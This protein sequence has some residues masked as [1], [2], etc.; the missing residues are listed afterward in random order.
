MQYKAKG[1]GVQVLNLANISPPG[2]PPIQ[3]PEEAEYWATFTVLEEIDLSGNNLESISF[4]LLDLP[5]LKTVKFDG[6][7]LS[8]IPS[9]ELQSWSSLK[10]YLH[11]IRECASQFG[12]RKLMF[13]GKEG[14]G[15]SGSFT[16]SVNF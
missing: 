7:P 15:K 13:V 9:K 2:C 10:K 8:A 14:A 6:N 16:F 3:L 12:E 1:K 4:A 11:S 5:S